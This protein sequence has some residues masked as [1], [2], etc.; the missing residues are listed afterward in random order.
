M[1]TDTTGN[2]SKT[3]RLTPMTAREVARELGLSQSTVSRALSSS[4]N[5]SPV[6]RLRVVEAAAKFGYQPNAIARGLITGR[7]NIVGIV[8]ANLT[9]PFYPEMLEQF[10]LRLQEVGMQS[11]LF[12][13]PPSKR[14]DDELPRLLQYQVDALVIISSVVSPSTAAL[15]AAHRRPVVL[16]NLYVAGSDI[17]AICCDNVTGGRMV[18]DYLVARGHRRMA[19]AAGRTGSPTNDDR[20]RGFIA[21]LREHGLS[22]H[23]RVGGDSYTY[24]AGRAA[25]KALV[26]DKPD[27]IFFANDLMAMGGIDALRHEERLRVPDDISVVGFD[28][29]PMASW[30]AYGLTTVHR[31][32]AL[33]VDQTVAM[34]ARSAK[35]E[36]LPVTPQLVPVSLVERHSTRARAS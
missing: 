10:S 33:M 9:N 8:I 12:N 24:E 23:A 17:P 32:I 34:L 4:P 22:L 28:D 27:A 25:A 30:L 19:F 1:S 36:H 29:V 2:D 6:T 31:P 5:V 18:A 35:G 16:F 3:D 20:E 7:S 13:I 21:R 26:P 11:L 14:V 15:C